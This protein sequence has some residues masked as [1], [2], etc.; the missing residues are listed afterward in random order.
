MTLRITGRSLDNRYGSRLFENTGVSPWIGSSNSAA[1]LHALES[2]PVTLEQQAHGKVSLSCFSE[3]CAL[4]RFKF[5]EW[6]RVIT[7][8]NSVPLGG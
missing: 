5:L 7:Q 1:G 2:N 4:L 8:E 6:T 3:P